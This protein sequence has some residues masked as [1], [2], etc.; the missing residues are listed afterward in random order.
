MLLQRTGSL[1]HALAHDIGRWACRTGERTLD[2]CLVFLFTE[3]VELLAYP[4]GDVLWQVM[5]E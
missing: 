1:V 3:V 4:V 2:A 5:D